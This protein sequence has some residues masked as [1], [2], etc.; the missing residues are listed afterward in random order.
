MQLTNTL[1]HLASVV[2]VFAAGADQ[3]AATAHTVNLA[4]LPTARMLSGSSVG[5]LQPEA[6]QRAFIV[7]SAAQ[8]E[9]WALLIGAHKS[10]A[11]LPA[12]P[13]TAERATASPPPV[14]V[15]SPT[16]MLPIVTRRQGGR[17]GGQLLW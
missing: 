14:S 4:Q 16:T 13:T 6:A 11:A 10:P 17:P 3:P 15:L 9:D 2:E 8:R 5:T 1:T 7:R 12:V